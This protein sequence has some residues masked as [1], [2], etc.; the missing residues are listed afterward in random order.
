V[1]GHL[2]RKEN[3][4]NSHTIAGEMGEYGANSFYR[5]IMENATDKKP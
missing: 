2:E 3:K 4:N 5:E 1:Y